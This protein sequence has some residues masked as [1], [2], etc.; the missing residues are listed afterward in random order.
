MNRASTATEL[1]A[2]QTD[3]TAPGCAVE[4]EQDKTNKDELDQDSIAALIRFFQLLDT[5]DRE[6][7]HNAEIM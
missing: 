6:V 3:G 5:W 7:T 4:R 2:G 1:S